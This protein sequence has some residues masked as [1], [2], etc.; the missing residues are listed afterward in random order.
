MQ[1]SVGATAARAG[2]WLNTV[3]RALGMEAKVMTILY[4][5]CVTL[6]PLEERHVVAY[7]HTVFMSEVNTWDYDDKHGKRTLKYTIDNEFNYRWS[8]RPPKDEQKRLEDPSWHPTPARLA[9]VTR[10]PAQILKNKF[11]P[12]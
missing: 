3:Y 9:W 6:C 11:I 10:T 4:D 1:E 12:C 8:T 7:L 5:S 2:Y